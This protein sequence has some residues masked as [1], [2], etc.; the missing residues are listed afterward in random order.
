VVR[1]G[2]EILPAPSVPEALPAGASPRLGH[3]EKK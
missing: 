1:R 3:G 2:V